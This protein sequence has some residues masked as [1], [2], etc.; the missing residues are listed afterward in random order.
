MARR[1]PTFYKSLAQPTGAIN[2]L[3]G[4]KRESFLKRSFSRVAAGGLFSRR[5][6]SSFT[7]LNETKNSFCSGVNYQVGKP[8]NLFPLIAPSFF[9]YTVHRR[10]F[11]EVILYKFARWRVPSLFLSP[12]YW[13]SLLLLDGVPK[14][15]AAVAWIVVGLNLLSLSLLISPPH[16][17]P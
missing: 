16:Q 7:K 8:F 12:H 3:G 13:E 14:M 6:C 2:N 15:V 17:G 1:E 11:Y 5:I 4:Q 9:F 10:V